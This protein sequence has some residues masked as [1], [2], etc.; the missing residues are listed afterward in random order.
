MTAAWTAWRTTPGWLIALVTFG[1]TAPSAAEA[2]P[3]G[4]CLSHWEVT[5]AI[6]Q[7]R[8]PGSCFAASPGWTARLRE[9][10]RTWPERPRDAF[11]ADCTAPVEGRTSGLR[12]LTAWC[13]STS[14]RERLV[15]HLD[16]L[17]LRISQSGDVDAWPELA[18]LVAEERQGP[19]RVPLGG[20][21]ELSL[22]PGFAALHGPR[23]AVEVHEVNPATATPPEPL[24]GAE[25]GTHFDSQACEAEPACALVLDGVEA[26]G[27]RRGEMCVA[28]LR[29]TVRP[30][31]SLSRAARPDSA[32][33]RRLLIGAVLADD[34]EAV[35]EVER[36]SPL[37]WALGGA[38][39][40]AALLLVWRLRA[41][42][43]GQRKNWASPIE[44]SRRR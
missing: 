44:P 28:C 14:T 10:A 34:V 20:L 6:V 42:R 35:C 8:G 21:M 18:P 43:T 5:A 23:G 31:W 27:V 32:S 9:S 17:T 7:A 1:V 2:Q 3:R 15:E 4:S 11:A 36:A 33:A 22:P 40:L 29:Q 38:G 16:G 25:A 39:L 30:G 37:G 24:V 13:P 26:R 19:L 12:S 41:E